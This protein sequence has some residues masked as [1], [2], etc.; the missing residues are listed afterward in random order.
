MDR[1]NF[2][3]KLGFLGAV[4]FL[5]KIKSTN[6]DWL[7]AIYEFNSSGN[8]DTIV[9]L[10]ER[11]KVH[12]LGRDFV[13]TNGIFIIANVEKRIVMMWIGNDWHFFRV[14]DVVKIKDKRT[15]WKYRQIDLNHICKGDEF[16]GEPYEIEKY[17]RFIGLEGK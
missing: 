16:H 1:R 5:P 14:G 13:K 10:E 4:P 3:K 7:E 15:P 9:P 17:G 2:V 12:L 8:P 6:E 11:K